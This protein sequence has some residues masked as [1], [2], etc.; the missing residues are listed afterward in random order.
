MSVSTTRSPLPTI[1]LLVLAGFVCIFNEAEMNIALIA[2][3]K[4]YGIEVTSAQWL[5]TGYMLIT[6]TFMPLS[7]FAMGRFG[8][9]KT[10]LGALT[11]LLFGLLV[12]AFAPNFGI[13]LAGRLI[14]ALGC[15]FFTPVMMA[16][17]I[18]LAPKNRLGTYN[19]VMMFVLM[20][21][22]AL[23]P[24]FAGV[25]L[26]SFGLPWLFYV[27]IPILILLI[28][29]LSIFLPDT[30]EARQTTLDMRSVI[31]SILGFGGVVY[32]V[33]NAAS[34]GFTA[35]TTL[36]PAGVGVIALIVYSRRQLRLERPL[37]NVRIFANRQYRASIVLVGV[38]QTILF[39]TILVAPLFLQDTWGMSASQAGLLILPS[40]V[41]TAIANLMAGIAYDRFGTRIVPYGLAVCTVGYL[42]V[43]ATM[44]WD[45]GKASFAIFCVVYALGL[46][47]AMTALTS[48]SLKSLEPEQYP[49]GSSL[50]N[51]IQQITGSAGTALFTIIVYRSFTLPGNTYASRLSNGAEVSF[52]VAALAMLILFDTYL[53]LRPVLTRRRPDEQ[54]R[55]VLES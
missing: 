15:S 34:A 51:T 17:I 7:A 35:P 18:T 38:L 39:G 36:V 42:G 53:L 2:I 23:S 40:G 55:S 37:L 49:D 21:A 13:L 19:G 26:T 9:R 11:V 14:Q 1:A 54:V 32:A 41:A 12:S 33:G 10:V 29:A 45:L 43:A 50:N 20:A 3:S 48:N 5:T 16:V 44:Y 24:T 8:S 52:L 47:F 4:I 46:P 22:P 28:I 6:G 31:F 27:I 30:I 25:I